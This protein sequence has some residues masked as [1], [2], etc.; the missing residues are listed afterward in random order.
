MSNHLQI[1]YLNTV[2]LFSGAVYRGVMVCSKNLEMHR[3]RISGVNNNNTSD[4]Q[5]NL[6]SN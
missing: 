4:T 2:N 6:V 1:L 5:C 3:K